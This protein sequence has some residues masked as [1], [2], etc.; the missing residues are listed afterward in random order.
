MKS[1]TL[2]PDQITHFKEKGYVVVKDLIDKATLENWRGQYEAEFGP[3]DDQKSWQAMKDWN[4]R[5][6]VS[7]LQDYRFKPESTELRNQP[8]VQAV[9]DQLGGGQFY[10]DDDSNPHILWPNKEEEWTMP[11]HGHVDGYARNEWFSFIL[12]ST[13]YIFDVGS[14]EGGTVFWPGSHI[15]T[16]EYYRKY[17]EDIPV[18]FSRR[19]EYMQSLANIEPVEVTAKAGDVIF[20]HHNLYHTATQNAG[21]RPRYGLFAR[22]FHRD[23]ETIRHEA[24]DDLWKYWGI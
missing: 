22:Y 8:G 7:V 17:P 1:Y 4:L 14:H 2:S 9:L 13:A 11:D 5:N 12:G 20:W 6:N 18:G 15:K 23:Q 10:C 16:W 24:P 21:D 3:L 19:E